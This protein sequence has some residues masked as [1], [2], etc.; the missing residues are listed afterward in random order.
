MTKDEIEELIIKA[1]D[2]ANG[3]FEET[4]IPDKELINELAQALQSQ[5]RELEKA[6]KATPDDKKINQVAIDEAGGMGFHSLAYA[7][8]YQDGFEAGAKWIRGKA[9]G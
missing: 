7:Q 6:K 8:S 9:N 5:Q 4:S 3:V 2:Q 1:K